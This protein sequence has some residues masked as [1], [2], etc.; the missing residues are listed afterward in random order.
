[1]KMGELNPIGLLCQIIGDN[2]FLGNSVIVLP[3]T[4]IGSNIVIGAGSV[5]T[6]NIPDN[7][8]WA[9]NPARHICS[10]EDYLEKVEKT[11]EQYPWHCMLK[12]QEKHVFDSVLE[13]KL[14]TERIKHFFK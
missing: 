9:G 3:N 1:M 13:K 6:K 7:T 4:T 12:T 5:V 14:I 10:F 2:C 11:T 8:V